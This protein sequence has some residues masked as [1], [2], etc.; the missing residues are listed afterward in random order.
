MSMGLYP[1]SSF[2]HRQ[3][4]L[5]FSINITTARA[6]LTTVIEIAL[7]FRS[8]IS[9]KAGMSALELIRIIAVFISRISAGANQTARFCYICFVY[10]CLIPE[11][12]IFL[13]FE[14]QMRR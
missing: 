3:L 6:G 8:C 14:R 7:D 9:R 13:P 2:L 12:C 4:Q 5:L 11:P 10:F 1:Y